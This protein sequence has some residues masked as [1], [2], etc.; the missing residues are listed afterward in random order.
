MEF[1]VGLPLTS[2]RN[3]SI[4]VGVEK[5]RKTAYFIPVMD[6]NDVAYV[7][8]VFIIEVISLHGFPKNIISD[9]DARFTSRCWT[10]L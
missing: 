1:V 7:S 9:G 10:S 3:D 8:W 5:L 4:M 6:T 2:H